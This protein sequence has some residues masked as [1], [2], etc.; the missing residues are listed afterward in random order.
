MFLGMRLSKSEIL[1]LAAYNPEYTNYM[2]WQRQVHL[3][4]KEENDS[5]HQI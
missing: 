2:K 1:P 5:D 3:W 4:R